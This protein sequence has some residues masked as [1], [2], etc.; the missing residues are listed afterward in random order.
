[1]L[2]P[3]HLT[4]SLLLTFFSHFHYS[5]FIFPTK[6]CGQSKVRQSDIGWKVDSELL[7]A[8]TPCAICLTSVPVII[9]ILLSL[10]LLDFLLKNS[11]KPKVLI[12]ASMRLN[13]WKDLSHFASVK[14][15]A[16]KELI[17]V[18]LN[19][20]KKLVFMRPNALKVHFRR[21][22]HGC[23]LHYTSISHDYGF[24]WLH[25]ASQA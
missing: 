19:D 11:I 8:T 12:I 4:Y 25:G 24:A 20:W 5:S 21:H 2:Y 17:S 10:I 16:Q 7:Y 3:F 14:P 1:M 6:W 15:N 13:T 18:R 22:Q 9:V 23:Q